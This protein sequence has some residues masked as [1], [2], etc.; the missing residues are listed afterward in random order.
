[1]KNKVNLSY[2]DQV[3]STGDSKPVEKFYSSEIYRQSDKNSQKKSFADFKKMPAATIFSLVKENKYYLI[4]RTLEGRNALIVIPGSMGPEI[5]MKHPGN[6]VIGEI[7]LNADGKI[8][9][10]QIGNPGFNK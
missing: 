5:F 8:I 6:K 10:N 3:P 2:E 7:V 9:I 1:M 4:Q